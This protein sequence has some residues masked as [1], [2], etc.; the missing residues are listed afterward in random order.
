MTEVDVSAFSGDALSWIKA[1][2]LVQLVFGVALL[3]VA[4]AV[5]VTL[6]WGRR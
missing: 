1:L 3:V 4:T 5:A 6:F 2:V